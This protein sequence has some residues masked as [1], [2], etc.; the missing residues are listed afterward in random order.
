MKSLL[1]SVMAL[2]LVSC[3][4]GTSGPTTTTSNVKSAI[5]SDTAVTSFQQTGG[6]AHNSPSLMDKVF[7][8]AY[9]VDGNIRCVEGA[10]VAFELDAFSNTV[11]INTT[12]NS[13]IDLNIRRGLLESM[14]SKRLLMYWGGGHDT[15]SEGRA[16]TFN[17]VG[18]FWATYENIPAG[19]G[20]TGHNE[21]LCKDKMTFDEST[22]EVTIEHDVTNSLIAGADSTQDCL[23]SEFSGATLN[24]YKKVLHYRFKDG[25]LEMHSLIGFPQDNDINQFCIDQNSIGVCD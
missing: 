9:A 18:S 15:R 10:P 23:N 5:F 11:Q 24:D 19:A 17:A 6:V 20:N 13:D 14:A 25:K 4:G 2:A 21:H 22:G 8:S 1:L 7:A 12:C 16:L 3:G